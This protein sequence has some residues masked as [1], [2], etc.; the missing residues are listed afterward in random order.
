M[1]GMRKREM[2]LQEI[3]GVN[4]DMM[5]EIYSFCV[6]NGIRYSLAYGSLIGAIRHQGF[7]PWDDDIDIMMPRPDFERFSRTFAST[8]GYILS[9]VYDDDTYVNYT[10]VYDNRTI[11]K[12]PARALRH[13]AGVW[14]DVYPIDGIPDDP[15][16]R[17]DQWSRL[18]EKTRL[19]MQWRKARQKI[20]EGGPRTALV[21]I[22]DWLRLRLK[23]GAGCFRRWHDAIL[24]IC[25]ENTFGKTESC[26]SL[27]CVEANWKGREEVFPTTAFGSYHLT[28]F[29]DT[30]FFV[31]DGY[32]E[33]LKVIFGDY[34]QIPPEEKRVSHLGKGWKYYWK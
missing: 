33:V 8:N 7:I 15:T 9:S 30:S 21:G 29:E 14:I 13:P 26:S 27:V 28:P 20:V 19:V 6:A 2:T 34:M 12:G 4:L 22:R 31:I 3:Q 1:M 17:E 10:R 25:R 32:D 23:N 16:A 11:V 24:S 5:K 18:R